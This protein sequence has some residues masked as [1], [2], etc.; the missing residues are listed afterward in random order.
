MPRA[1][2]VRPG[3]GRGLFAACEAGLA[4]GDVLAAGG[5]YADAPLWFDEPAGVSLTVWRRPPGVS[6]PE[7]RFS[8]LPCG[9]VRRRGQIYLWRRDGKKHPQISMPSPKYEMATL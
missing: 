4:A 3:A 9:P 5:L 6:R 2:R 1:T 7:I 8:R